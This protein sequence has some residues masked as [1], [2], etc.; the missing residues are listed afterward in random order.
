MRTVQNNL[1]LSAVSCVIMEDIWF[2][3]ENTERGHDGRTS[4]PQC[5]CLRSP[6]LTD[7]ATC[8]LCDATVFLIPEVCLWHLLEDHIRQDSHCVACLSAKS[9]QGFGNM[10]TW[11]DT[12]TKSTVTYWM[13]TWHWREWRAWKIDILSVQCVLGLK[14]NWEVE[15]SSSRSFVG[16]SFMYSSKC[17]KECDDTSIQSWYCCSWSSLRSVIT[18]CRMEVYVTASLCESSCVTVTIHLIK[19]CTEVQS[20]ATCTLELQFSTPLNLH[21]AMFHKKT[22]TILQ[23]YIYLRIHFPVSDSAD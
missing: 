17:P 22:V 14:L 8:T 5:S 4:M 6:S 23:N 15:S 2:R 7:S 18:D 16:K 20:C 19:Y 3:I 13:S 12:L 1:S 11:C 21:S 10:I 9:Q